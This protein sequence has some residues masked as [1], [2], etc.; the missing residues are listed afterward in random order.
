MNLSSFSRL[1][2]I[3]AHPDDEVLGCGGT[4]AKAV[5]LGATI[6]V[7][8]LGE[9]VSARFPVGEYD[10]DEYREQNKIR[11]QGAID[12]MHS[13]GINDVHFNDFRYCCQFDTI[14]LISL[15]K[16]I[17]NHFQDF[18][19]N[20]IFTHNPNEVNIDHR[21]T[22]E[23]VEVA[24]RPTSAVVPKEIYTF[25][26]VCSGNWTFETSFKPNVF[27]DIEK[28]FQTKLEA[29]QCYKGENRPFPFPRS[30]EGLLTL[31]QFRGIMSGL[32]FAEAFR[33]VRK[34]C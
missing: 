34:V 5:D 21:L 29:W 9:G 1:L 25:E 10:N 15:V 7:I 17:E 19:P 13:L 6:R 14:P 11:N 28:Y 4:L 18:K 3:A 27:V 16:G 23:A 33:M 31:A 8:F 12:A 24:C 22:Y 20:I 30:D 26:I 32:K 2:V